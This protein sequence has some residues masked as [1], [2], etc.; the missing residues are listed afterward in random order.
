MEEAKYMKAIEANPSII[1][2][3]PQPTDEMKLLALKKQGLVLEY[4]HHPTREMEELAINQNPRAIKFIENPTEQMMI[5]AVQA[6]WSILQY[7]K[8]PTDEVIKLALKQSGWAIQYAKN[9]S[10]TLQ[11]LAVRKNYD[12]IKYIEAPYESVQEE[13]VHISYEAL[14]YIKEPSVH[15]ELMGVKSNEAAVHFIAH[16]D[17]SKILLF[18]K[19]NIL[20]IKYFVKEVSKEELEDVLKEVLS[21][22]DVEEKYV[23]DFLNCSTIE[24]H[25][26]LRD[27]VLFIQRY[28]SKKTKKI[29]VDERLK[30]I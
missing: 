14:R 21:K 24:R 26:M 17:K 20:V 27:K 28:G 30:M 8:N 22:E 2:M 19:V 4:I 7:I 12:A 10:E 29:A 6:G 5:K 11:L 18:L 23:R 16:L 15:V 1:K 13:A 3:I 9:P 25:E